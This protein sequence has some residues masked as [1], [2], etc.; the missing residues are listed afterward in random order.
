MSADKSAAKAASA[1][2]YDVI[3]APRISEKTARLQEVS[4]QYAFEVSRSASKG[5]IKAAI[6]Q[7]F[8]VT[9]ES[10][11]VVNVKGKAKSFRQRQG[12]RG[13]SRKAYVRLADG[14]SIDVM[15]AKV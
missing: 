15:T 5:E 3:R 9:V 7:L 2:V 14:Q 1:N 11:N 6:E 10:V 8:D 13:N 4:N 12:S